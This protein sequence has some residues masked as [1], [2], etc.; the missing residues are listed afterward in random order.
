M[1]RV[2]L[3][4]HGLAVG[5]EDPEAFAREKPIEL[6]GGEQ[7]LAM[8]QSLKTV[9]DAPVPINQRTEPTLA[10]PAH[11]A[12]DAAPCPRCGAA[13]VQRINRSTGQRFLGCSNFPKCRGTGTAIT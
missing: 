5:A 1:A 12:P 4:G 6:I 10:T 9:E 3:G 2:R 13:L 7:L 11:P 8:I